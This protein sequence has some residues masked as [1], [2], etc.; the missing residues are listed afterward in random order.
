MVENRWTCFVRIRVLRTLDYP[1][2]NL[3]LR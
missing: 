2:V 3:N 1:T